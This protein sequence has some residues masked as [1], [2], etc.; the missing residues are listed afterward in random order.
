MIES[1]KNSKKRS[2]E[3]GRCEDVDTEPLNLKRLKSEVPP[4]SL[5]DS[6]PRT[7]QNLDSI[8]LV[9]GEEREEISQLDYPYNT[10]HFR[11]W[12]IWN[13]KEDLKSTRMQAY[14]DGID[15]IKEIFQNEKKVPQI[16]DFEACQRCRQYYLWF[17]LKE[18]ES[19][20]YRFEFQ[21]K[22]TT[23][24]FF[25]R[26]LLTNST[27]F[28]GRDPRFVMYTCWI[29]ATKAEDMSLRYPAEALL[30]TELQAR[31]PISAVCELEIPVLSAMD[32]SFSVI[33]PH[34]S[35]QYLIDRIFYDM[36]NKK[37]TDATTYGQIMVNF[38]CTLLRMNALYLSDIPFLYAPAEIACALL[39]AYP[40]LPITPIHAK[41]F[42]VEK[43]LKSATLKTRNAIIECQTEISAFF[44]EFAPLVSPDQI[45]TDKEGKC[46][47]EYDLLSLMD[48][49]IDNDLHKE[50][51][52]HSKMQSR[53]EKLKAKEM[54]DTSSC[55]S[56]VPST[57]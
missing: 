27:L 43:H 51:I 21:L 28:P 48:F 29:L 35:C 17:L 57:A 41:Q 6:S 10:S 8:N 19:S 18:L 12:L 50:L 49:K 4:P 9:D 3:A 38:K 44:V 54:N 22:A 16:S 2:F 40:P 32:F 56:V 5:D 53:H 37:R 11:K 33:T 24:A 34:G 23:M 25:A 45:P 31:V 26:Y 7:P 46:V 39:M 20:A 55:S 36:R 15:T 1:E 47:R 14:D 13:G 42:I 30:R 52:I